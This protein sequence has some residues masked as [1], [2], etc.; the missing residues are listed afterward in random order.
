M[1]SLVAGAEEVLIDTLNFSLPKTAGYITER[2]FCAFQTEGSNAYSAVSGTKI[3]R[4]R[5]ASEGWLDPSTVRFFFDVVNTDGT[6]GTKKLRPIGKCHAFFRRFRALVRGVVVEDIFDYN[7]V[8]EMFHIL[9]SKEA[10]ANDQS[11]G[12]NLAADIMDIAKY[13]N[14]ERVAAMPA[15]G[16]TSLTVCFKP[17]SGLFLQKKYINLK[18][19]PIELEFELCSDATEPIISVF[20]SAFTDATTSTSWRIENC[21]IK[22]DVVQIDNSLQNKH[23]EHLLSGSGLKIPYLTFI[24]N[25]QTITAAKTQINVSRSVSKLKAV[26]LTLDRA[27]TGTRL[28]TWYNKP[29]NNFY[30]PQGGENGNAIP[31]YNSANDIFKF[32]ISSRF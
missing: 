1:D 19:C 11:E 2:K 21:M 23:E 15:I 32:T 25:F 14:I 17:L 29:W 10:T 24:S 18:Y 9:Q 13:S 6:P 8:S 27:L 12:F 4:F 16:A 3:I 5:L 31:V 26:Y 22:A 7:R 28:A 30:N 20:G